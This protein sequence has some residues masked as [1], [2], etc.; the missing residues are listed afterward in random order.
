MS[1]RD[2]VE[3]QLKGLVGAAMPATLQASD[4]TGVT[5]YIDLSAVDTMSCQ[6]SELSILVPSLQNAPFDKL[7]KWAADLSQRI[8]Y[9]LENIGPL[10]FDPANGQVLIRSTPPHQLASGTQY[11]EI[12]LSSSGNGNFTL[13]RYKS[14]AGQPGRI[15]AD[16]QMTHEVLLRLVE[17]LLDTMP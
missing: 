11:Y 6:F 12:M 16:L 14:V 4:A 3:A 17:D 2:D 10:E 9:L 15:A 13:R 5:V 7:K 8:T 1:I